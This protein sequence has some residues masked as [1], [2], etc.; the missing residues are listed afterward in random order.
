MNL[1]KQVITLLV[2]QEA[3]YIIELLHDP[4]FYELTKLHN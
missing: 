4:D 1:K 3:E 2:Q